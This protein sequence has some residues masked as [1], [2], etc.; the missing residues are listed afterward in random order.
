MENKTTLGKLIACMD[1]GKHCADSISMVHNTC[2]NLKQLMSVYFFFIR[3]CTRKDF[4]S[5]EFMRT[6]LGESM[7]PWGGF[8]DANGEIEALK[9]MAFLG[10]C[11][12]N[13]T[14]S[15]YNIHQCWVRH[16]SQLELRVTEHSHVYIDCFEHSKV[17]VHALSNDCKVVIEQYGDSSVT[18]DGEVG[19]V[20]V[21][22][23]NCQTY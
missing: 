7:Q 4:P 2:G 9:R 14:T 12:C 16:D 23:H 6:E 13:L 1:N 11:N 19:C 8:I 15:L 10:S 3:E 5:L 22:K 20:A 18:I 17:I 21:I